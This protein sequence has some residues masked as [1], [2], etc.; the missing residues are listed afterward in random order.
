MLHL[1]DSVTR[2]KYDLTTNL[3]KT[4]KDGED[5]TLTGKTL[6]MIFFY[7]VSK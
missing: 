3:R 4:G 2:G 6:M 5:R 7:F 1:V